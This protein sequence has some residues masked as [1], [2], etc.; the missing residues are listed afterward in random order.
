MITRPCLFAVALVVS[1]S[2][3]ASAADAPIDVSKLPPPASKQKVTYTTDIKP[4][5]DQSCVRC[6]GA[7]KPKAKLQLDSLEGVLKGGESGKVLKPGKSAESPMVHSITHLGNPDYF[8]PPPGNRA[9]IKA[10]TKEQ[11]GLIRA[12]IDQGAK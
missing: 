1:A 12:W 2:L 6:H 5:L 8:M 11:V 7:E 4:I 10:L 3:N 9:G